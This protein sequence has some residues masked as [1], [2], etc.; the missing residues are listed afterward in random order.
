MIVRFNPDFLKKLKKLDVRIR[1]SFK[2]RISLFIKNPLNPK[3]RNH[4]LQKEYQGYRSIDVTNDYRA[5][6]SEKTEG[7][8]IIAYFIA[9]GI[10][11]ELYGS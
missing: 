7:E 9:I 4:L 2:E 8:D 11:K 6:Y 3:L 10:H 1:K 5:V